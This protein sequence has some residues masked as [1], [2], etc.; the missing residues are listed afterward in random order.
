MHWQMGASARAKVFRN[1][2]RGTLDAVAREGQHVA[3]KGSQW[4]PASAQS[5]GHTLSC[6]P[7]L[8]D[9]HAQTR[10]GGVG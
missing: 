6:G 10:A 9:T 7:R 8:L 2:F 4:M 1:T 3:H 5:F